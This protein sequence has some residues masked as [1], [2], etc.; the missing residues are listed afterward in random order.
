MRKATRFLRLLMSVLLVSTLLSGCIW[1]WWDGGGRGGGRGGE[2][3]GEHH[4]GGHHEG[5]E[6]HY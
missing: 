1:P 5:E 2:H 6:H 4:E 3:G